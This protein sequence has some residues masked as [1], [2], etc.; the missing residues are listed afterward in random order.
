MMTAPN[1]APKNIATTDSSLL[2]NLGLLPFAS[3]ESAPMPVIVSVRIVVVRHRQA[4]KN[5]VGRLLIVA[6]IVGL[7]FGMGEISRRLAGTPPY[8]GPRPTT[9]YKHG[10]P[11]SDSVCHSRRRLVQRCLRLEFSG[12][13][14]W[15]SHG[16]NGGCS[17]KC[18]SREP[19]LSRID[20][21]AWDQNWRSNTGVRHH[22]RCHRYGHAAIP[23]ER[24][25]RRERWF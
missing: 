6:L 3:E 18:D 7:L 4:W 16:R 25:R 5:L 10:P 1:A 21:E 17:A 13:V 23:V 9:G 11:P 20:G 15:A 24:I 2:A 14:L 8:P 12:N 22:R 19:G